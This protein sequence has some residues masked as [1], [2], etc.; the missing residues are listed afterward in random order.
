LS[1][2]HLLSHEDPLCPWR[3]GHV[4][5][6]WVFFIRPGEDLGRR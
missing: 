6:A 5:D 3:G 4:T 1:L 2:H